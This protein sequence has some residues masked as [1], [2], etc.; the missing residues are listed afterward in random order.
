MPP[1]P[2]LSRRALLGGLSIV[3]LAGL[4]ACG[5]SPSSS[6]SPSPAAGGT[7]TVTDASGNPVEVPANPTKVVTT[8]YAATQAM[9]DLGLTPIGTGSAGQ[10][11]DDGDLYATPDIWA[12]L[13][14]VPVVMNAQEPNIEQIAGL[15]PELILVHNVLAEDVLVQLRA[16]APVY[17]FTLRGGRRKNWQGRVEEVADALNRTQNLEQLKAEWDTELADA[18]AKYKDKIAGLKVA[19]IGAYEAGNFYAW[20]G[21]N[22]QGTILLPL[23]FTW[24]EQENAA[25]Q[26]EKE[27]EATLSNEKILTTVGDADVIYYDTNIKQQPNSFMTQLQE[28]T[29]YQEVPAVKANHAYP[30][31]KNTIAGFSDARYNLSQILQGMDQFQR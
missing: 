22:M 3:S 1:T 20:G 13:K 16:I 8:H 6:P 30:F 4:V 14:D 29:L 2:H 21:D 17:V 18:A 15:E 9:M 31:G 28:T 26:G 23:G 5:G 11:A 27:P 7:R 12:E 19:V 24:S 25:V 10:G